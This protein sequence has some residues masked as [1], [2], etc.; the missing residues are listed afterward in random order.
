MITRSTD[1]QADEAQARKSDDVV[2][3]LEQLIKDVQSGR[4]YGDFGITFSAQGGKI[5]HY[6]EVR[7]RTF[8]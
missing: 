3:L 8:K 5:G 6:E 2:R 4:M 7:R 1:H